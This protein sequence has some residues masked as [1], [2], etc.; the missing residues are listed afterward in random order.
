MK[1]GICKRGR[2]GDPDILPCIDDYSGSHGQ[3]ESK[4]SIIGYKSR[5][6]ALEV[7]DEMR[8]KL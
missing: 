1:I 5:L 6:D 7:D 3:H 2:M 4:Y 8:R